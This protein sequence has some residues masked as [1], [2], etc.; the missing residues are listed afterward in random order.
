MNSENPTILKQE[1]VSVDKI[2]R[3]SHLPHSN[4]N[5]MVDLAKLTMSLLTHFKARSHDLIS[6][7]PLFVTKKGSRRSD[8][9]I[10]WLK[11]L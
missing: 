2:C 6:T 7:I 5:F 3:Q 10:S 1:V 4:S 11:R 8:G 9:P